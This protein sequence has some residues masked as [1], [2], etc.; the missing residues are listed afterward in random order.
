MPNHISTSSSCNTRAYFLSSLH[1]CGTSR[2]LIRY[3]VSLALLVKGRASKDPHKILGL[4][5]FTMYFSLDVGSSNTFSQVTWLVF[6]HVAHQLTLVLL[7]TRWHWCQSYQT[8]GV[9]KQ[10]DSYGKRHVALH[11]A[12]RIQ[13]YCITF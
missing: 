6:S 8:V 3:P 12:F 5:I 4:Y 13:N 9:R 2:A 11:Q 7:L 1:P 10:P